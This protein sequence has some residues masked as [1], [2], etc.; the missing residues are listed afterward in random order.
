[1]AKADG[2]AAPVQCHRPLLREQQPAQLGAVRLVGGHFAAQGVRT[3]G[4]RIVGSG[5][6]DQPLAL[7]PGQQARQQASVAATGLASGSAS[8][9]RANCSGVRRS[10]GGNTSGA[11]APTDAVGA[12]G[13][14]AAGAIAISPGRQEAH[15]KSFW[16]LL[17]ASAGL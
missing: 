13:P 17:P 7:G 14:A 15:A 5:Q 12:G 16:R 10:C 11:T 2:A 9:T 1:M 4:A 6:F 8:H 3:A